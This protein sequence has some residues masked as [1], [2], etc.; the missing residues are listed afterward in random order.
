MNTSSFRP[1]TVAS[2][3]QS[4]YCQPSA[5]FYNHTCNVKRDAMNSRQ[6]SQDLVLRLTI[7]M[8]PS[9]STSHKI[10]IDSKFPPSSHTPQGSN[11][12][13]PSG[14]TS[15]RTIRCKSHEHS[16]MLRQYISADSSQDNWT[17]FRPALEKSKHSSVTAH[18][19]RVPQHL[20]TPR[21]CKQQC[22]HCCHG[23]TD[24]LYS[25]NFADL[26]AAGDIST[27]SFNDDLNSILSTHEGT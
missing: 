24:L 7:T 19:G 20:H 5:I 15:D 10:V 3:Q 8:E 11:S 16:P 25:G 22:I 17:P 18:I 26:P 21:S 14:K 6:V 27:T 23:M 2:L 9:F 1:C 13:L 4:P 12:S